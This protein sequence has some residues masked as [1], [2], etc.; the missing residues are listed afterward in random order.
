MKKIGFQIL[1]LFILAAAFAAALFVYQQGFRFAPSGRLTWTP[2]QKEIRSRLL[3]VPI[4]LYHNIDGAGVFSV[5]EE[6]LRSHFEFLRQ[7]DVRVISMA[8][9]INRLENPQP[10]EEKVIVITFDDGY[11]SM[12]TKLLPLAREYGYPITLFVYTN[13]VNSGASLLNWQNLR[14]MDASLIDIQCHGISHLDLTLADV[15]T[16]E[17]RK[18]LF[19]E[20][21]ASKKLLEMRLCK[22]IDYFA[23]PYGRYSPALAELCK[24]AGYK[25]AFSTNYGNNIVSADNYTLKRQH[26]KSNYTMDFFRDI[27]LKVR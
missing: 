13:A 10:F 5:S 3:E 25:R 23:F 16:P 19:D 11:P 7:N 17:G 26:I 18:K 22:Q 21:Y 2:K 6:T 27:A 12:Y 9:L 14:E 1:P 4:L 24:A 15:D 20:L 8:D